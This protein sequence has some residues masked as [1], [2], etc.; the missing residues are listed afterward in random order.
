MNQKKS[1][2]AVSPVIG[3]MLLLVV[4]IVIAAV[5]AVFASGVG[6][7]AEPAPATAVDVVEIIGGGSSN[8]AVILSCIHG[9]SLDLSKIS[10]K[11]SYT[12]NRGYGKKSYEIEMPRGTLSGTLYPGDTKKI[13]DEYK[14]LP[15]ANK[16]GVGDVVDVIVYYGNHVLVEKKMSVIEVDNP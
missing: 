8:R 6:A 13:R 3:V 9:E 5:V 7:D 16:A 12:N 15:N 14:S 4:T 1:E 10:M 11:I 2:D